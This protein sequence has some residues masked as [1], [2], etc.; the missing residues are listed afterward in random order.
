ML[1]YPKAIS[2]P[3]HGNTHRALKKENIS[4][5]L[6]VTDMFTD[7]NT[8]QKTSEYWRILYMLKASFKRTERHFKEV[9]VFKETK[10]LRKT[11]WQY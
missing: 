5:K 10:H 11:G 6:S 1:F 8:G 2:S 7:E 9:L 3:L 4:L